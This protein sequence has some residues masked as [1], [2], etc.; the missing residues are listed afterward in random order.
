MNAP[1]LILLWHQ[2]TISKSNNSIACD[3]SNIFFRSI[4]YICQLV[5]CLIINYFLAMFFQLCV[6][7]KNQYHP[8]EIFCYYNFK[9]YSLYSNHAS[10]YTEKISTG[11]FTWQSSTFGQDKFFRRSYILFMKKLRTS[12]KSRKNVLD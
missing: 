4:M 3:N 7:F 10:L 12:S 5:V 1:L 9:F 2:I 11:K 8:N 6:E